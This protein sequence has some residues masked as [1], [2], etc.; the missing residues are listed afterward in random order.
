M[1]KNRNTMVVETFL[2]SEP[3]FSEAGLGLPADVPP[4][5]LV[6]F[7]LDNDLCHVTE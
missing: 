6:N 2:F 5:L 7:P 1:E 3:R 4:V